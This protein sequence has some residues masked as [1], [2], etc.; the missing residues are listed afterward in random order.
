MSG[1]GRSSSLT[2]AIGNGPDEE[3]WW[4]AKTSEEEMGVWRSLVTEEGVDY[5]LNIETQETQWEKPIELM[6]DEEMNE[7]GEWLWVP[8]VENV[9]IPAKLD[10]AKSSASGGKVRVTTSDNA[11]LVVKQSDTMP[12]KRSFLQRITHDLTLLDD[13]AAPLILHNLRKRP[14]INNNV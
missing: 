11:T 1:R 2:A 13:L 7:K 6:T 12:M 9:Y 10:S 3:K 14:T 5:Y 4:E 8:D